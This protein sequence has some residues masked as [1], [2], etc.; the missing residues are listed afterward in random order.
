MDPIGGLVT[1]VPP[2]RPR[3]PAAGVN[4]NLSYSEP[5]L[6]LNFTRL[7]DPESV[8]P[9]LFYRIAIGGVSVAA[10]ETGIIPFTPFLYPNVWSIAGPI[11]T[12]TAEIRAVSEDGESAAAVVTL[13]FNQGATWYRPVTVTEIRDSG[14][15]GG[16]NG[17]RSITAGTYDDI[18]NKVLRVYSGPL[19]FVSTNLG[20]IYSRAIDLPSGDDVVTPAENTATDT[21][22]Y[23][24]AIWYDPETGESWVATAPDIMQIRGLLAVAPP[25]INS[26]TISSSAPANKVGSTL[27]A[28]YDVDGE[29]GVTLEWLAGGLPIAGANASTFVV[30]G[31]YDETEITVRLTAENASPETAV[32]TATPVTITRVAPTGQGT[33]PNGVHVQNSGASITI[34]LSPYIASGVVTSITVSPANAAWSIDVDEQAAT[35]NLSNAMTSRE[36]T[37]TFANSGGSFTKTTTREI[38]SAATSVPFVVK[39][40]G[41]PVVYSSVNGAAITPT[42]GQPNDYWVYMHCRNP[43]ETEI[44]A[45]A[46]KGWVN[47]YSQ[48]A[49]VGSHWEACWYR[50]QVAAGS[51]DG[52]TGVFPNSQNG[53][54]FLLRGGDPTA[55]FGTPVIQW[56]DGD[57][58]VPYTGLTIEGDN[59]AVIS[60][61]SFASAITSQAP[62]KRT[63]SEDIHFSALNRRRRTMITT[64]NPVSVFSAEQVPNEGSDL[65]SGNRFTMAVEFKGVSTALQ[66]PPA[67]PNSDVTEAMFITDPD[68]PDLAGFT[69]KAGHSR[70]RT[71]SDIV[72]S[73]TV[74]GNTF[75]LVYE[76]KGGVE[77]T[78]NSASPN[79]EQS[80]KYVTNTP[81]AVGSTAYLRLWWKTTISGE[82]L[83]KLAWQ[84]PPMQV[85]A[86]DVDPEPEPGDLTLP[87]LQFVFPASQS[88]TAMA[89]IKEGDYKDTNN[90]FVYIER[91]PAAV[92][93]GYEARRGN[94]N[95]DAAVIERLTRWTTPNNSPNMV[96][97]YPAQHHLTFMA[98]AYFAKRTPRVWNNVPNSVKQRCDALRDAA[99]FGTAGIWKEAG[100]AD[101]KN[102]MGA[103]NSTKPGANPNLHS[104]QEALWY[105]AAAYH[106][107]VESFINRI[108]TITV[109]SVAERLN[110]LNLSNAY[111]SWRPNRPSGAPSHAHIQQWAR[112]QVRRGIPLSQPVRVWADCMDYSY[113][114]KVYPGYYNSDGSIGIKGTSGNGKRKGQFYDS[115]PTSG[116][117]LTKTMWDSIKNAPRG[118]CKEFQGSDGGGARSSIGYGTHAKFVLDTYSIIMLDAGFIKKTDSAVVS[119]KELLRVAHTYYML[120]STNHLGYLGWGING[121]SHSY[122]FEPGDNERRRWMGLRYRNS[123]GGALLKMLDI[124]P[125]GTL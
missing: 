31:T 89:V 18:P 26:L 98:L 1:L 14:V 84:A 58:F 13:T 74:A 19:P 71:S 120:C 28:N 96:G 27:T 79:V 52:D 110:E 88:D 46:G 38:T 103:N 76:P 97:A 47:L 50:K 22:I 17:R 123:L 81:Q 70:L 15:S 87:A 53:E 75:Q 16:F 35:L 11:F 114:E 90:G 29:T 8:N 66:W 113:G 49:A 83:Y 119:R 57:T 78:P 115:P 3:K 7:E 10:E 73:T 69:E 92:A 2:A 108:N 80:W 102:V 106:G 59:S 105:A 82:T 91:S 85:P 4:F 23:T 86:L 63:D 44:T 107:S 72:V 40:G 118:R 39:D 62:G 9:V 37:F 99:G 125:V 33:I 122:D 60:R 94:S 64:N 54:L 104:A 32:R 41:I 45:P 116:S 121:T 111:Q 25:V 24:A 112:R 48:G 34:N 5:F 56:L 95:A 93:V 61:G 68:D 20:T 21:T 101:F 55:P 42:A 67:V 12:R 30:T 117:S 43:D 65:S 36:F 6:G 51:G 77:G 109:A 100:D 124:E